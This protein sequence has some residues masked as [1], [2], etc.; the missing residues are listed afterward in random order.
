MYNKRVQRLRYTSV[1]KITG[2]SYNTIKKYEEMEN[3]TPKFNTSKKPAKFVPFKDIVRKWLIKDKG[4]PHKQRHTAKRIHMR[5]CEK[6]LHTYNASYRNLTKIMANG[7]L[8]LNIGKLGLIIPEV[9]TRKNQKYYK[10]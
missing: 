2:C 3:M 8:E 4:R 6:Y 9:V 5:L 10:R 1:K 7:K